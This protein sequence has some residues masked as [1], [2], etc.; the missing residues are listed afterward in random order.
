MAIR[1]NVA[2][3]WF[4]FR[5]MQLNTPHLC[6]IATGAAIPGLSKSQIGSL[7]IPL[8]PLAE[9]KRIVAILD[10]AFEAI[11]RAEDTLAQQMTAASL[12]FDSALQHYLGIAASRPT[13]STLSDITECIVD[14]E[15][16]T[17]PLAESGFPSIRTPNIGK[18]HLILDDVN[19]VDEATYR[20]WTRRETPR[21]GDLILAREA[22]AGNVGVIPK[23]EMVC[24][25]QRTV[26]IRPNTDMIDP[27]FLAYL[28][29]TPFIQ[30][31]LLSHSTGTTVEHVNLRDIRALKLP[32]LPSVAEQQAVVGAVR[33]IQQMLVRLQA[34]QDKKRGR[35]KDL[36][37]AL[38]AAG[39][40]G[41]LSVSRE[42]SGPRLA[43]AI[44]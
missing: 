27:H 10:E 17:A 12:L 2:D 32:S 11:E 5:W 33:D 30:D 8:P 3:P 19:L 31:R 23:G 25:G 43:E 29:L 44:V 24:L 21:P 20:Q 14:C 7:R 4:V 22:P 26:L 16:K 38:L 15:H 41:E 42:R 18:G 36:R 37:Q 9:Q 40:R 28:L 1:P 35:L 13:S 39:F 6:S 34:V